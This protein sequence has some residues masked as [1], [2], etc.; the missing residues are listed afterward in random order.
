MINWTLTEPLTYST[1]LQ[2]VRQVVQAC[3]YI[4]TV[5]HVRFPNHRKKI[6]L[7]KT[8]TV[9]IRYCEDHVKVNNSNSVT[10]CEVRPITCINLKHSVSPEEIE[11]V[12]LSAQTHVIN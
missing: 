3:G 9:I 5:Q 2:G 8:G 12:N 11:Y 6:K 1:Y 7:D 10:V 4:H